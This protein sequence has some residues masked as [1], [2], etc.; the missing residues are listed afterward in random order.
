[1]KDRLRKELIKKRRNLPKTEVLT[2]SNQ[3]KKRLFELNESLPGQS[4][5]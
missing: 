2:K 1:M 4:Q 5:R 3:I